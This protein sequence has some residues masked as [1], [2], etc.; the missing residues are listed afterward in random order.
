MEGKKE[1]VSDLLKEK[2]DKK[3]EKTE[4]DKKKK[5]EEKEEGTGD[6]NSGDE[7]TANTHGYSEVTTYK[8]SESEDPFTRRSRLAR[9]PQVK[10]NSGSQPLT[11]TGAISRSRSWSLTDS[12]KR[13]READ[14]DSGDFKTEMAEISN[15][16]AKLSKLIDEHIYTKSEIKD[17]V[18]LLQW[19]VDCINLTLEEWDEKPVSAKSRAVTK[20]TSS[21]ST[22][23]DDEEIEAEISKLRST[24]D[25]RI[26]EVL[27][28][29][30]DFTSL[31][32]V[33]DE[34]WAKESFRVTK[35]ES[36]NENEAAKEDIVLLVDPSIKSEDKALKRLIY[37]FAPL[38]RLVDE[39]FKEGQIEY[40][41]I[42][43]EIISS[44]G[45][46]NNA[47]YSNTI[48]VLPI[49]IAEGGFEDVEQMF[50]L[51][52]ELKGI[53]ENQKVE[54]LR[55]VP[56]GQYN[57]D[58]LRKCTEYVFRKSG[59]KITIVSKTT[60][61]DGTE[62][63]E[64]LPKRKNK[65]SGSEK[66]IVK[67][68]GKTYA[69]LLRSVKTSVDI[70]EVGVRV[71]RMKKTSKGDLLLEVNGRENASKL[72]KAISDKT[73]GTEVIMKTND[74]IIHINDI[75]ADI[76]TEGLKQ[77]II[78][79]KSGLEEGDIKVLSLRP[80]WNGNQTATVV[81]RKGVA[82]DFISR[83]KV[84]IGWTFCR[85][86]KRVQLTRCFRCLNFGHRALECK[87]ED[88][89]SICIKCGK[90]GHQAKTCNSDP[91]CTTCEVGG[92]RADQTK[93]PH[94][95]KLIRD[96]NTKRHSNN[97]ETKKDQLPAD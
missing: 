23:V 3:N 36:G 70:N 74:T 60:T 85:V 18:R 48:Y 16:A 84:K 45:D 38:K 40:V 65:N 55:V 32:E 35:L 19:Q 91:F 24:L 56:A 39:G 10:K 69:D 46:K 81:L 37:R 77:E 21:K 30:E 51:C 14:S 29:K 49:K 43:T 88:R 20:E 67:A 17:A 61:N 31:S 22:Q 83:G 9:S 26:A 78:K 1:K 28:T 53:A 15:T 87:G 72:K 68:Q 59:C 13:P 34:R 57:V 62:K 50:K 25:E 27:N 42:Q 63:S 90:P 52:E 71:Q 11:E 6:E 75:D 82:E 86:R 76:N 66:I 58:Y 92:H 12:I 96:T 4:K 54:C 7:T 5:N 97:E 79:Q 8:W 93:C 64:K 44:K 2:K 47:Q 94:F 89:S 95:R 80:T 33:I 73:D 41:T